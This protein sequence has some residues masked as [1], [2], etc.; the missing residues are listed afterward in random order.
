MQNYVDQWHALPPAYTVDADGKPLHSW[1]TLILPYLDQAEL[2]KKIDRSKP[3]DDPANAE[4][5]NT[6]IYAYRCPSTNCPPS[7]TTYMAIVAPGSCLRSAEPRP[8]S[9]ITGGK[10][11][12]A[13][14]IE[15]DP[16][17]SVPWMA[18]TDADEA[19]ILSLGPETKLA[20][21]GGMYATYVD[22]TVQFLRAELPV[23][24]RRALI[25]VSGDGK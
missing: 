25:S 6:N 22:G 16:K 13:M 19:L 3:W 15:V 21:T 23:A 14:V 18:P 9:E 7:H 2:Y 1:R 8:V 4:A 5:R 12:T 10:A 24:E 20:H 11:E 17:H